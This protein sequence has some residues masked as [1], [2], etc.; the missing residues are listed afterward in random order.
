MLLLSA[1]KHAAT[2]CAARANSR[3]WLHV[4]MTCSA[5]CSKPHFTALM[6][7]AARHSSTHSQEPSRPGPQSMRLH[8]W[9]HGPGLIHG[10]AHETPP[11]RRTWGNCSQTSVQGNRSG[12]NA[13]RLEHSAE[14]PVKT[15]NEH[16][17]RCLPVARR[18]ASMV[19]SSISMHCTASLLAIL[20]STHLR[21][22]FTAKTKPGL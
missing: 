5:F 10:P 17:S 4:K 20:G 14:L 22:R 21:P 16:C 12:S 15:G 9:Y 11:P 2:A 19:Y 3:S 13:K 18:G 1:L 8:W 7:H 6:Q